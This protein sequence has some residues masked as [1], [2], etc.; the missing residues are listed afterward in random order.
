LI[1]EKAENAV[2]TIVEVDAKN[3]SRECSSCGTVDA[4]SRRSQASFACVACGYAQNADV[5]AARV[6]VKR[7]ESRLAGSS[8]AR[9]RD[10]DLQNA[11][12]SGRTRLTSQD[13]A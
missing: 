6:I 1:V 8:G 5:N 13:A 4:T 2:R 10:A 12:S 3:T 9:A 7:A 11:L